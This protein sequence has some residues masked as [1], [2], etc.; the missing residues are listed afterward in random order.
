MSP[1]F[2]TFFFHFYIVVQWL[3]P[4][5]LFG[6]PWTAALQASL[7]FSISHSLLKLV[8]IESMVPSNHFILCCPLLLLSSISPSIRVFSNELALRIRW[9][10][11]RS[12]SFSISPS[13]EYLGLI[14]FRIYWFDL[15]VH[16]VLESSLAP[17]FESISSSLSLL[18][19]PTLTSVHDYW[20]NHSFNH[21]DL[22][23]QS[24]FSAF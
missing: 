12:F 7:S 23:R 10:K 19:G 17:Q 16:G 18:Y 3:S 20:E 11:Y 8:S 4:V 2:L 6:T 21:M 15:A 14:S 22:C 24:D 1:A 9:P 5:Q 13:N